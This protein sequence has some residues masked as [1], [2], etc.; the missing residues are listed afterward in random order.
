M[1]TAQKIL[2]V[3]MV[4]EAEKYKAEDKHKKEKFLAKNRLE[5]YIQ[6]HI[7]H[8]ECSRKNCLPVQGSYGV[9]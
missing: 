9:A 7:L 2:L 3:A 4:E 6:C 1:T 8:P 5:G